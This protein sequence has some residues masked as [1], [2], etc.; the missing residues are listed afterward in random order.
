MCGKERGVRGR[1]KKIKTMGEKKN[2]ERG[3]MGVGR[4]IKGRGR[5]E[6]GREGEE[7]KIGKLINRSAHQCLWERAV[8]WGWRAG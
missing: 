5:E 7:R 2:E 1:E 3:G 6:K 4:G 8:G